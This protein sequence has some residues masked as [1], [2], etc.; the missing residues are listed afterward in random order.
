MTK[1]LRVLLVDDHALFRKGLASLIEDRHDI[2]VVAQAAD[3][4]EAVK[5]ARLHVPDLILLD[6]AMPKCS[7]VAAIP[8]LKEALPEVRIVMLTASEED[9]DL[10]AAI[11]SGADGYLLKDLEPELL[12]EM[13]EA[14]RRGEVAMT[15][16]LATKLLAE[17]RRQRRNP[18]AV[19]TSEEL[20]QREIEVLRALAG[21]ATNKAI[22]A[23]L[24][25]SENTV[26]NHL[27]NVLDKLLLQ[28]RTQ[29]AAYAVRQGLAPCDNREDSTNG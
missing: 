1:H 4:L 2:D 14:T 28:N 8:L 27:R 17:F 10:F 22:S 16:A 19:D 12:F 11:Q 13:L 26:K 9:D 24:A 20:T 7:G 21:G 15:G 29:A 6:V 25:I 3:G 18:Q 5:L 23:A